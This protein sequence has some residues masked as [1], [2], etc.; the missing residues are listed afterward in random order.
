[1]PSAK[2]C[3][4]DEPRLHLLAVGRDGDEALGGLQGRLLAERLA[5]L[6]QPAI[7]DV[8]LV[9]HRRRRRRVDDHAIHRIEARRPRDRRRRRAPRLRPRPG[10]RRTCVLPCSSTAKSSESPSQ[11]GSRTGGIRAALEVEPLGEDAPLARCDVHDGDAVVA[12]PIEAALA[13]VAGDRRSVGRPGRQVVVVV[14]GR[15][16]AR[17]AAGSVDD[18]DLLA[19]LHVPVVVARGGERQL[20]RV[21]RPRR[22]LVLEVAVRQLLRLRG[23]VG[24]HDEDVRAPVARPAHRVELVAVAREAAGQALLLVLLLVR[25]IGDARREGKPRAVRRPHRLRGVL[26]EIREAQG[27]PAV[28]RQDVE[29][30]V[31]A[32]AVG[33]EGDTRAVGR[34]AGRAV[35][36]LA[37]GQLPRRGGAVDGGQPDRAA[38]RVLLPVDRVDGVGD[39]LPVRRETRVRRPDD[40]V[41]ILRAHGRGPQ[42][43]LRPE[44]ERAELRHQP[45]RVPLGSPR[46]SSRRRSAHA[47][48]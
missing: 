37:G 45:E 5:H 32:V 13:P 18:P 1:M 34:P 31:I 43:S 12:R 44:R 6:G 4:P 33:R 20:L 10:T 24:R 48:A 46:R 22:R 15:D 27:L 40:V 19:Q 47:D 16:A 29:L 14:V 23:A 35:R 3:G 25:R 36:L 42:A 26:L 21:G 39:R 30:L 41:E 9:R 17:L 38:I 11:I 2:S 8:D 7:A 28:Q